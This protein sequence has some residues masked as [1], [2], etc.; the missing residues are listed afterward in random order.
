MQRLG[1]NELLDRT[2]PMP[3]VTVRLTE[4]EVDP[5]EKISQG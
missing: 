3:L 4:N 2:R 5:S 1:D